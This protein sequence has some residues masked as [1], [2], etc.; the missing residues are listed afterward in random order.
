MESAQKTVLVREVSVTHSALGLILSALAAWV[1]V[2]CVDRLRSLEKPEPEACWYEWVDE[3]RRSDP[4][5]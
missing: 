2:V 1:C 5:Y 3:E 4:P